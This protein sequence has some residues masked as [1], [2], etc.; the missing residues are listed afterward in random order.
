MQ[1]IQAWQKA[2]GNYTLPEKT[3]EPHL[4]VS[5]YLGDDSL[6]LILRQSGQV[7]FQTACHKCC[8]THSIKFLQAYMFSE[9]KPQNS[10]LR[11]L[12]LSNMEI[13]LVNSGNRAFKYK[14]IIR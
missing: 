3:W 13:S 2:T 12:Y 14:T 5:S 11:T 8:L 9:K 1:G 6:Q 7:G 10:E 4:T